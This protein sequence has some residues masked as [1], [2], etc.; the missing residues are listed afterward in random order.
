MSKDKTKESGFDVNRED[1]YE[2][3]KPKDA[4]EKTFG[5]G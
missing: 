1:L 5:N 3:D 2:Y 4:P